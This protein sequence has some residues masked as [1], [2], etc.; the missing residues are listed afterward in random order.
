MIALTIVRDLT[1][2]ARLVQKEQLGPVLPVLR[3]DQID[4][5]IARTNDSEYGLGGTICTNDFDRGVAV[6]MKID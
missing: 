2:D 5:G 1:D 4:D 3:Y 6:A